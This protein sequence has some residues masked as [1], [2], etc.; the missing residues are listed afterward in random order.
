MTDPPDAK[1]LKS[2]L[3]IE[4]NPEMKHRLHRQGTLDGLIGA[5]FGC[6]GAA[7]SQE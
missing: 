6:T 5:D 2:I 7:I 4:G 3:E 1:P